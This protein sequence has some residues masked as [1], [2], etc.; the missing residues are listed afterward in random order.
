MANRRISVLR[1]SQSQVDLDN[2]VYGQASRLLRVHMYLKYDGMHAALTNEQSGRY[3]PALNR[4]LCHNIKMNFWHELKE[5]FFVLAPMDDVTD[6]VFRQL[7]VQTCPPDVLFT[8]FVSTAGLQS[9]AGRPQALER[10][11]L[12]PSRSVP[13]V[14]QI[15]GNDP[16]LFYKTAADVAE[17]GFDGI[18]INMGCPERSVVAMGAGGGLIGN[19]ALVTNIIAATKA[20]APDLPISVK[21]RLGRNTIMTEDWAGFLLTQQLAALT[22]HGRTVEEMSKVPAHW[23][24]IAKAVSLRDQL[25]PGTLLIGNGDVANRVQGLDQ[26]AKTGVDGVMIGRGV[27]RDLFAFERS[28]VTHSARELVSALKQHFEL[29]EQLGSR[30][31]FESITKFFKVY[32]RGWSGAAEMRN[33]LMKATTVME[34]QRILEGAM[35]TAS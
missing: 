8:E 6:V 29:Y 13:Q 20:G 10:L 25:A 9:P 12:A 31:S 11:R 23:D 1:L 16:Q 17:L 4:K 2:P 26:V 3:C 14:A 27:L 24:E 18:D 15:W 21:T 19:I 32:L 22:L 7:M 35:Q 34:A 5:P 33:Q 30:K 28:P